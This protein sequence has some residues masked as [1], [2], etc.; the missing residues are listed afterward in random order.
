MR[1]KTEIEEREQMTKFKYD[2]L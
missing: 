2:K 1:E